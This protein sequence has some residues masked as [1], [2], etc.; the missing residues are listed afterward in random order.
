[1]IFK[2]YYLYLKIIHQ[3]CH[4][5]VYFLFHGS[6]WSSKKQSI[7]SVLILISLSP[8]KCKIISWLLSDNSLVSIA[9]NPRNDPFFLINVFPRTD[10]TF[11]NFK[12]DWILY[13]SWIHLLTS[14]HK[15]IKLQ[16]ENSVF[17]KLIISMIGYSICKWADTFISSVVDALSFK[18]LSLKWL[19]FLKIFA[20]Q[21]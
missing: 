1:M 21:F 3:K 14:S 8:A 20:L 16:Y 15:S 12:T 6:P 13:F 5:S 11:S 17:F 9:K 19:V 2:I 18:N 10:N 7:T 4:V